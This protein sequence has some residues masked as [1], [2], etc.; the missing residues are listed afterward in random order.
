MSLF[1]RQLFP[2]EGNTLFKIGNLPAGILISEWITSYEEQGAAELGQLA[3]AFGDI[4]PIILLGDFNVGDAVGPNIN[5]S[6]LGKSSV[7]C[8]GV[9]RPFEHSFNKSESVYSD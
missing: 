7:Q 5:A 1:L 3:A 6:Q 4:S 2:F 9:F 8:V